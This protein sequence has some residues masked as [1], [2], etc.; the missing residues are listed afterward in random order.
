MQNNMISSKSF[1][2]QLWSWYLE[3]HFGSLGEIKKHQQDLK[4][5]PTIEEGLT[6][7]QHRWPSIKS[8]CEASPLFIFSAGWRSG[9]TLLQRLLM[10]SGQVLIWGE[11]YSHNGLIDNLS[12]TIKGI[13]EIFPRDVWFQH[14]NTND[15]TTLVND[16]TANFYPDINYLLESHLAF[17]L[18]LFDQPAR[19]NGIERWG[20]KEVRLTMDHALYLHWL[21]PKAK[22]IFL[23][24]NPYNAYLSYSGSY[25]YKKWPH[26][27]VY[28]AKQFGEHWQ[29][30][31]TGYINDYTKVSGMLLSYENLCSEDFDF[32][33]LAEFVD[34]DIDSNVIE[35]KIRGDVKWKE[36]PASVLEL[37]LL[38]KVVEPL[39]R[40][41]GYEFP[42][43]KAKIS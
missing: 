24:R 9:S 23:Y 15:P 36:D 17:F 30:L 28:T 18:N 8:N 27:P 40:E 12:S 43:K 11:P 37:H 6:H 16:F 32:D 29:N 1:I 21:F 3:A 19:A 41:L 13:T 31:L 38:Q 7:F 39:A 33:A 5:L 10:S 34:L 20:I 14:S 25:W 42:P 2:K 4:V 26:E 35:K 22:F